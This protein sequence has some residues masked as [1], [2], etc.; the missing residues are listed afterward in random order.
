MSE[1][2]DFSYTT[3]NNCHCRIKRDQS[4]KFSVQHVCDVLQSSSRSSGRR[5]MQDLA[6]HCSSRVEMDA[7]L[8]I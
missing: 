7:C 2:G 4:L 3:L 6:L 5:A 8:D 1:R